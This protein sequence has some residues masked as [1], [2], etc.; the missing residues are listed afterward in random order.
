MPEWNRR[1]IDSAQD[2]TGISRV[3]SHRAQPQRGSDHSGSRQ[4]ALPAL[5][6][7][8]GI[9]DGTQQALRSAA[10]CVPD[11]GTIGA[12]PVPYHSYFI[13]G[14]NLL[15]LGEHVKPR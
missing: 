8:D 3:A 11:A 14:D 13:R 15:A 9:A 12:A 7:T 5:P 10:E 4:R 1:A 2:Q 6:H